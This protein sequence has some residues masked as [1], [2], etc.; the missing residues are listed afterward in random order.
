MSDDELE[1]LA[2]ELDTDEADEQNI[3]ETT[4]KE[5]EGRNDL[6]QYRT[7]EMEALVVLLADGDKPPRSRSSVTRLSHPR[8]VPCAPPG[9]GG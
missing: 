7:N 1:A 9:G 5:P 3:S 6:D 2:A 4:R 8:L